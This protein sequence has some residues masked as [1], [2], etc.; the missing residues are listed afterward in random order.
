MIAKTED[1]LDILD[2]FHS[3]PRH[4]K[5]IHVGAGASGLL[6]AYKARKHLSN[7]E[8]IC[9]EKSVA[10]DIRLLHGRQR[11]EQIGLT[12]WSA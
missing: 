8:L 7:Y 6:T 2:Q 9:Y 3:Q 4:L 11:F 10:C 1:E 12:P 5:I